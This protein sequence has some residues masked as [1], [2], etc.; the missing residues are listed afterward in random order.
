MRRTFCRGSGEN[1]HVGIREDADLRSYSTEP[2]L[3]CVRWTDKDIAEE[4]KREGVGSAY[5]HLSDLSISLS[6]VIMSP[7]SNPNPP[8][9][10]GKSA[11]ARARLASISSLF[12]LLY[13]LVSTFVLS[14]GLGGGGLEGG[15]ICS[16][17]C[18][19]PVS[20]GVCVPPLSSWSWGRYALPML[21]VS[22]LVAKS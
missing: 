13:N 2:G 1:F 9:L 22:E 15:G 11:I 20:G 3:F 17:S 8:N 16:V 21:Y 10:D 14:G 5:H 7:L 4:R 19:S 18:T 6:T 12:L